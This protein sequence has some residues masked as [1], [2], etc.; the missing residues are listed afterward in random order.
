MHFVSVYCLIVWGVSNGFAGNFTGT[1]TFSSTKIGVTFLSVI[2]WN[3]FWLIVITTFGEVLI[4]G[5]TLFL[6]VAWYDFG[7]TDYGIYVWFPTL[8]VWIS[9]SVYITFLISA[10]SGAFFTGMY[11]LPSI[12]IGK[13]VL[14]VIGM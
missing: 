2:G 1:Y 3:Y 12:V 6:K 4:F 10:V 11:L 14:F 7:M 5:S 8:K 13:T 9:S